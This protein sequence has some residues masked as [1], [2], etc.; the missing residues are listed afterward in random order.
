MKWAENTPVITLSELAIPGLGTF[1][2]RV[3]VHDGLYA[4]TW[5]HGEVAGH[6][7]GQIQKLEPADKEQEQ[8][9][10]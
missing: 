7:F 4:G 8:T 6:L 1:S 10:R 2:A 9:E 5:R 3:V